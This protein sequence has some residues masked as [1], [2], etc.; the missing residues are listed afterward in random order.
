VVRTSLGMPSWQPIERIDT[1]MTS[2]ERVPRARAAR[3]TR[4]ETARDDRVEDY[5]RVPPGVVDIILT[6]A[7]GALTPE[8]RLRAAKT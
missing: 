7:S 6:L 5:R 8:V 3:W 1:Y 4:A 2:L